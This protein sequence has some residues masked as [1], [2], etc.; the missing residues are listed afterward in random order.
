MF[1]KTAPPIEVSLIFGKTINPLTFGG[2]MKKFVLICY[3][4]NMPD[5][6]HSRCFKYLNAFGMN[7]IVESSYKPRI[8]LK[9]KINLKN[10]YVKRIWIKKSDL[11]YCIVYTLLK[12]ISTN[13]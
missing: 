5:H 4:Y 12:T 7:R 2:K 11:N 8:V 9:V 6:I 3:H 1:V 10:N 13:S